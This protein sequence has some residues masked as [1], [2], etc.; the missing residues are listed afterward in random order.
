MAILARNDLFPL[1]IAQ[2]LEK[3]A[4]DRGMNVT[5]FEKYAINTMDHSAALSQIKAKN[6]EMKRKTRL[7]KFSSTKK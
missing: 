5:F 6:E 1:Q 2:E 4:K 3:S 7:S